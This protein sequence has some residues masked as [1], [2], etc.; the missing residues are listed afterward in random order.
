VAGA[1]LNLAPVS[2]GWALAADTTAP[3]LRPVGAAARLG[4][5]GL[6]AGGVTPPEA[7]RRRH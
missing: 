6:W 3:A 7:W 2:G 5:R 1:N 4:G